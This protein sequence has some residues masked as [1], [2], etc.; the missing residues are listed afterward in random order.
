MSAKF[1]VA[2]AF[3]IE[4]DGK[5]LMM[6]RSLTKDHA[7]GAWETGSGRLESGESL[8]EAVYREVREETGLQVEI[9]QPVATFRFLRGSEGEEAVGVTFWCRHRE[10]EVMPSDE[11]DRLFWAS[12]A[13][14]KALVGTPG[15]VAIIERIARGGVLR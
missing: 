12:P 9:V 11:H 6:R 15:E 4:R 7:P 2:V 5:I 10:G 8:E 13:E 14:A 1:I 3:V